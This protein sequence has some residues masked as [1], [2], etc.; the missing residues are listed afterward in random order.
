VSD[1]VLREQGD[2]LY[3]HAAHCGANAYDGLVTTYTVPT[4]ATLSSDRSDGSYA[5]LCFSCHGGVRPDGFGTTPVDIKQFATAP[6]GSGGHSIV[7]SDAALPVGSPLPCFECHNAHGSARGNLA[8]ISDERGASLSTTD[9]AGVRRF[10]F[11]CHAT[12]DTAAGWDSDNG[13]YKPV[14]SADKIVGVPRNGGVLVLPDEA[15]HAESSSESCYNCHGNDYGSGGNNVHNPGG[16]DSNPLGRFASVALPSLDV[17][18]SVQPTEAVFAS[19]TVEPTGT[20]LQG[21]ETLT[22]AGAPS[23]IGS[24][25]STD[26]VA[27]LT[28][29]DVQPTYVTSATITLSAVDDTGGVG[30][31]D[32]YYVLDGGEVATGTVVS[33]SAVGDHTLT[34]WSIDLAGNVESPASVGFTIL[35]EQVLAPTG[36]V[37]IT[38]ARL[39]RWID[40]PTT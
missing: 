11:T 35:S 3:C 34:F 30:V 32:T 37:R 28:V 16:G 31:A 14:S 1:P 10:C 6:G 15:A 24:W 38:A 7:S 8:Q 21:P 33:T 27:P 18:G 5:A 12:S 36:Q 13:T 19:A 23:A 4:Q 26:L 20:V 2:C 22:V 39:G 25:I 40:L 9:A 17:S 29:S